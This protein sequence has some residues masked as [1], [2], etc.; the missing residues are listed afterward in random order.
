MPSRISLPLS[1]FHFSIVRS[2]GIPNQSTASHGSLV[3]SVLD[4]LC[5]AAA[6]LIIGPSTLEITFIGSF[7]NRPINSFTFPVNHPQREPLDETF[8]TAVATATVT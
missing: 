5:T 2:D 8:A 4:F 1:R 6:I 7:G 3:Y